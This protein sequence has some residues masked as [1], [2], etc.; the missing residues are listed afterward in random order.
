MAALRPSW[1]DLVTFDLPVRTAPVRQRLVW[2]PSTD[3]NAELSW[4]RETIRAVA[5]DA[6]ATDH[7]VGVPAC[8]THCRGGAAAGTR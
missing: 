6:A 1:P 7:P 4:L 2:H 5:H 8:P 3:S